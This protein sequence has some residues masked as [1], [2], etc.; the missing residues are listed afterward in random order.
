MNIYSLA[1]V[2]KKII[3]Y[4]FCFLAMHESLQSSR[5]FKIFPEFEFAVAESHK[6]RQ[7]ERERKLERERFC[8][9]ELEKY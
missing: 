8:L 9:K 2:K 5:T 1:V 4:I 6:D 3:L 7:T